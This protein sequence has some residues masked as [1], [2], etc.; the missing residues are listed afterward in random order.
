MTKVEVRLSERMGPE[1]RKNAE[2]M[3]R[4]DSEN[5]SKEDVKALRELFKETPGL[6]RAISDM[7]TMAKDILIREMA[8]HSALQREGLQRACHEMKANLGYKKASTIERLLIEQ[9]VLCWL[10]WS[11]V[12][13]MHASHTNGSISIVQAD[14]WERRL[15]ANQRRYLRAVE[16]L[17]RVRKLVGSVTQINIAADGGQQVNIA[18]S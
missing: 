18:K 2:L 17:A 1:Q 14:F 7:S 13:A 16:S 9:V 4:A 8:N 5:P 6:A 12:E 3:M 10:R 15:S 11:M